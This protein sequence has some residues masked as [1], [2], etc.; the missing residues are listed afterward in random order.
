MPTRIAIG[1]RVHADK[2]QTADS[3]PGLFQE[4]APTR[5]LDRLANFDKT[6]GQG[7][8][9][10]E[11]RILAPNEKQPSAVVKHDAIDGK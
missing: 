8:L 5:L 3:N 9:T 11:R 1:R 4:F 6:A 10:G 7:Q 2:V